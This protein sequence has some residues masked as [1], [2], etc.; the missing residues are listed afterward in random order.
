MSR[1]SGS[2]IQVSCTRVERECDVTFGQ[3]RTTAMSLEDGKEM[4]YCIWLYHILFQCHAAP[5]QF[6][7]GLCE[8]GHVMSAYRE[9]AWMSS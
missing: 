8:F 7:R 4:V 9:E 2:S 5:N 6:P 1:E 3:Y